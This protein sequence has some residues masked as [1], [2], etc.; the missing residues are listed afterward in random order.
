M[1]HVGTER[2][3]D[4]LRGGVVQEEMR[5]RRESTKTTENTKV[6]QNQEVTRGKK[7]KKTAKGS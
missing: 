3:I 6:S 4:G 5:H 2:E 1:W 7:E